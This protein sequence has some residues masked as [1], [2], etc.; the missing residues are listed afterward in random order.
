MSDTPILICYDGSD[1]AD[2]AIVAAAALFPS[3]RAIVLDVGPVLT[4]TESIAAFSPVIAGQAFGDENLDEAR[5]NAPV[6]AERARRAGLDAEGRARGAAPTRQ[7]RGGRADR[8][9]DA[10]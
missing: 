7:A 3:R 8:S 4:D 1:A 2:S 9:D 5:R 6:G 10:G